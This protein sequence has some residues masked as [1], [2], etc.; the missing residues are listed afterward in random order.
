MKLTTLDLHNETLC[1]MRARLSSFPPRRTDPARELIRRV[2]L[3]KAVG[4]K[5]GWTPRGLAKA[6]DEIYWVGKD[7]NRVNMD[8]SIKGVL[9]AKAL[10]NRLPKEGFSVHS[11]KNLSTVIDSSV[12]L[13]SSG[14]FLLEYPDRYETWIYKRWSH[15]EARRSILPTAEHLLVQRNVSDEKPFFLTFYYV[16]TERTTP[17]NFRIQ[18]ER[19]EEENARV[20]TSLCDQARKGIYFPKGGSHCDGCEINC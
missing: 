16:S 17:V 11:I 18:S 8:A 20:I 15:K 6:W 9:S 5:T 19:P 10:Y 3:L 7:I 4:R 14:D 1:P 13:S 2:F 12:E